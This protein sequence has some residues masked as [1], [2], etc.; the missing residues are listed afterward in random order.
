MVFL[1][2]NKSKEDI[3]CEKELSE[4]AKI[5]P[6][7]LR[8]YHTLTRH[9]TEKHGEWHGITGRVSAELLKQC[10]FPEPS[11]ETL[12]TYCGPKGLNDTV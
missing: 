4:Y 8:L 7:H 1:Y 12:I 5:N 6:D 10:R 2:S 3:L 11:P 9:Q